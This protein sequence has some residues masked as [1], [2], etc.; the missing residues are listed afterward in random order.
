M[1]WCNDLMQI[2]VYSLHYFLYYFYWFMLPYIIIWWAKI[3]M[4]WLGIAVSVIVFLY[5]A[6][7]Y[8]KHNQ[9][10]FKQFFFALPWW[11]AI[12]Y[13]CGKTVGFLLQWQQLWTGV[14]AKLLYVLSPNGSDF[15]YVGVIAWSLTALLLFFFNKSKTTIKNIIDMLFFS[16]MRMLMILGIF[17]TLSDQVIWQPNDDGWFA[18]RALVPYS[19]IQAYGQVYPYGLIISICALTSYLLTKTLQKIVV[20]TGNW[21][22]WF[23]LFFWF[24]LISFSYQLYDQHGVIGIGN[25]SF[26][27]KHY[28]NIF[29]IIIC[30]S[31]YYKLWKMK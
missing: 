11:F 14:S 13:I 26:D 30:L 24:M 31:E 17:L 23:A 8:C 2:S 5:S 29:L 1:R 21:Y 7:V 19:K 15:H 22:I 10:D 3:S 28:I 4:F 27:I 18:I 9:L 16:T 20:R 25:R 12:I 6:Y